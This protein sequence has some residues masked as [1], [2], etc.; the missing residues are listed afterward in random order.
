MKT[1]NQF[2]FLTMFISTYLFFSFTENYKHE[3]NTILFGKW[4]VSGMFCSERE[5]VPEGFSFTFYENGRGCVEY[6]KIIE[7]DVF[8]WQTNSDT[9]KLNFE[10]NNGIK[11]ILFKD[12]QFIFRKLPHHKTHVELR[13][14]D[15]KKCGLELEFLE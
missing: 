9:L 8:N 3:N 15:F 5:E 10:D 6:Q 11:N 14:L 2:K 4:R 7:K 12:N 1:K 13:Y